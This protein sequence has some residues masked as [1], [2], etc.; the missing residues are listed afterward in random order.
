MGYVSNLAN[1]K[2][3]IGWGAVLEQ[4]LSSEQRAVSIVDLNSMKEEFYINLLPGWYSYRAK[5][6]L[7]IKNLP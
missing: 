5:S 2:L 4:D 3:V 6:S 1:N 7:E